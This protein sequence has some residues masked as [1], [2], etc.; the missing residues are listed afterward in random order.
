MMWFDIVKRISMA[1]TPAEKR[2]E[3][4][5]YE[6]I[7]KLDYVRID[8]NEAVIEPEWA[9]K[10][11]VWFTFDL[12]NIHNYFT[13]CEHNFHDGDPS[14]EDLCLNRDKESNTPIADSYVSAMLM[15]NNHDAWANMWDE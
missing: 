2:A 5:V 15:A 11:N 10:L 14:A 4:L 3:Q 8:G 9:K 7:D 1:K 13:I 12:L 6:T